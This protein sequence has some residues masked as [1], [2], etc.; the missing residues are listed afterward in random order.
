MDDTNKFLAERAENIKTISS[1]DSLLKMGMSFVERSG[2]KKYSYN[3]D[4]LGLPII[5]YPQDIVAMQE[6][7]W[8]VKPDVIIETG[9]AR[10]GSLVLY[11]SIL[12]LIG[13]GKV[14]GVELDLREHNKKRIQD[15][16]LSKRISFVE[17]SSTDATTFEKVT[18]QI[19]PSDVVMVILDSNHTEDHVTKEL[20]LYSKLVTR[21]SYLVV[22]DTS[23]EFMPDDYFPN[24]DWGKGNN[25]HSSVKKF[26]STNKNFE[27]DQEVNGKLLISVAYDGYLKR[28]N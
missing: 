27:I 26:L 21:N 14:V 25:P 16:P 1:D 5:Q 7:V 22:M 2:R 9:V 18:S 10:G 17:G 28:I 13:K 4:W 11:A 12:D 23:I 20:A 19:K 8:K 6:I 3:F 15:H 24:R